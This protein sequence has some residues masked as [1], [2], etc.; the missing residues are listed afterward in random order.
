MKTLLF[1]ISHANLEA[2]M[3]QGCLARI[4]RLEDLGRERDHYVITARVPE[5]HQD[6]VIRR[7]ADR[8]R[9]VKW[10]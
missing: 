10:D 2:L 7:S 1:T 3:S 4:L 6:E 9:W 8:P 5:Q